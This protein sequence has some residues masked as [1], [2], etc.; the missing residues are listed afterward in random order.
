[1]DQHLHM[2]V[3]CKKLFNIEIELNYYEQGFDKFCR[4]LIQVHI[5]K[6]RTKRESQ[7]LMFQPFLNFLSQFFHGFKVSL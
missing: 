4:K 3:F 7:I 2:I 6:A 1:V 5:Q